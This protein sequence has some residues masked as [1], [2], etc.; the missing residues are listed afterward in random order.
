MR[1]R[2]CVFDD[3]GI[4]MLETFDPVAQRHA[5]RN[6]NLGLINGALY[7]L[8]DTLTSSSLV[9]PLFVSQLT[10][11]RLLIGLV[12]PIV[13]S[14]WF[15]PQFVMSRYVQRRPHKQFFYHIGVAIRI[16]AWASLVLAI[17]T[18]GNNPPVLLAVFFVL[19]TVFNLSAG[20]GGLSFMDIVAKTV[21]PRRRGQYFGGRNLFG[22]LLAFGA[23]FGV[24]AILDETGRFPFPSNYGLLF[25]IAWVF[26]SISLISFSLVIE[27][28]GTANEDKVTLREQMIRAWQ[29]PRRDPDFRRF[30]FMRLSLIAAEMATPFYIVYAEQGLRLPPGTVGIYLSAASAAGILSNIAW[31]QMSD[32]RGNKLL[33]QL[34]IGIGVMAPV[35]ALLTPILLA[36][37]PAGVVA[38]GFILV[39][40][41]YGAYIAGT[42]IGNMNL[43]LEIAPAAERPLYLGT[44]NTLL[45]LMWFITGL[46]GVVAEYAGLQVLFAL[47]AILYGVGFVQTLSMH[48]PRH[49]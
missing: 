9:L 32:R 37:L 47:A 46:G 7:I 28:A 5:R 49:P 22:G 34:N 39:F 1:N 14:G 21:P 43:I 20:I 40:I 44:S 29:L 4:F 15:L 25:G 30:L 35:L 36:V 3:Q 18:L 33:M 23:G 13:Q 6:F 26:L 16:L 48:D 12:Q 27:P 10:S 45:G 17:L 8:F 42:N 41:I 24:K 11:S 2:P 31:S 38:N 19:L